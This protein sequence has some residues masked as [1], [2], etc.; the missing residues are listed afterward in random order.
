LIT[1]KLAFD[2][3]RE[4]FALPGDIQ[5]KPSEGCNLLIKD[6]YARLFTQTHDILDLLR[7]QENK[8]IPAQMTSKLQ[9]EGIL[10]SVEEK[11]LVQLIDSGIQ[12]LDELLSAGEW[13]IARLQG[14]ILAMEVKGIVKMLPGRKVILSRKIPL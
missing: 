1:A 4:I 13:S 5:R 3:D 7:I 12:I 14:I 8:G 11:R 2:Y 9:E 6:Q 10:L